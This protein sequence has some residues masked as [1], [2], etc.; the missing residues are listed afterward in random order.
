MNCLNGINFNANVPNINFESCLLLFYE[1][2]QPNR[3]IQISGKCSQ[4]KSLAEFPFGLVNEWHLLVM[5][6][7][8]SKAVRLLTYTKKHS[9]FNNVRMCAYVCERE[10]V[11]RSCI[12]LIHY[13][14]LWFTSPLI[15]VWIASQSKHSQSVKSFSFD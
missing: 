14:V 1:I 9:S 10:V 4:K 15:R 7:G 3:C 13:F 5:K 11:Q 12:I 2:M 6:F 8:Q